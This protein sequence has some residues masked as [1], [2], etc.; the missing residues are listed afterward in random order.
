MENK[1]NI[2]ICPLEWGLGHAA[3]MIVLAQRLRELN[4][5][6]YAGAGEEHLALFR[7]EIPGI[8]CID[9][10]GFKPRYSRYFPQYS[11]LFFQTPVLFYH[12]ISEHF[13]LKRIIREYRIEIVISDNR[14]GLWNRKIKT[15]YVTHQLR[16]PFPG[17]LRIFEF[18]GIM[19]HRAVIKKYSICMIPDLPDNTINLSGRLSHDIRFPKNAMYIGILSRF[20]DMVSRSGD[21]PVSFRHNTVILSGPEPQRSILEQKLAG[22][23]MDKE[24]QTVFLGGRPGRNS[25]AGKSGNIISFDHLPG[26]AMKELICSSERIISRPGY[27]TIMELISLNRSALLIPTPGQTEQEYL[28][29]WLGKR[30]WFSCSMQKHLGYTPPEAESKTI[31]A[32]E[33]ISKSRS[34]LDEALKKISEV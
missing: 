18:T 19:L 2:L 21:S 30:G 27:T 8:K 20:T 15:V 9:F 16:I 23:F 17:I 24:P 5:N 13:R 1:T 28:A 14:F 11:A 31:P 29:G 12:I 4:Y 22:I 33:I 25:P 32:E 26:A 3:R 6:V 10:P 7:S 34:L